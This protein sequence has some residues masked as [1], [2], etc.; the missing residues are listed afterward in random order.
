MPVPEFYR[1]FFHNCLSSGHRCKHHLYSK[2]LES[3]DEIHQSHI[4]ISMSLQVMF[5]KNLYSSKIFQ[6]RH[7]LFFNYL[8][9][10]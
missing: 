5:R 7:I 9:M 10:H 2:V 4:F 3:A 6:S 8:Y 1:P